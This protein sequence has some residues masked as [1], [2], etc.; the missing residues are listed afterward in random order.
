MRNILAV[1]FVITLVGCVTAIRPSKGIHSGNEAYLQGD[2]ERSREYYSSALDLATQ[3]NWK[4]HIAT[5]KYGLGRSY[6]QLCNFKLAEKYLKEAAVLEY[7]ISQGKGVNLS[8]DYFQLAR[9]YYDY[10]YYQESVRYFQK[11][12]PLVESLNIASSDP[13]GY[14]YVIEDYA[15]AIIRS[16]DS[17]SAEVIQDKIAKLRSDNVG[18][19][20]GFQVVRFKPS[21]APN[22]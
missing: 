22:K 3:Q 18:K 4:P 14:A 9:L 17:K 16:G 12:V 20:A 11:A 10:G 6:G 21:C 5:A 2:Y 8:Q 7:E 19:R 1:G 13:I 15:D